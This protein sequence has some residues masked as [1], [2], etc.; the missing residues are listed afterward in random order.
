MKR[1]H[2]LLLLSFLFSLSQL[3]LSAQS[4]YKV[5][6]NEKL[7]HASLIVE[8]KVIS[9]HSFWGPGNQMIFTS[10]QV[11]I[12][13]VF[14]GRVSSRTIEVITQG[15]SV[16]TETL[17]V[18]DLLS[19]QKNDIGT[20]MCF[21]NKWAIR[22]PLTNDVLWDVYSSAQG[23]FK[24]DLASNTAAAPFVRYADVTTQLYTELSQKIGRAY[25]NV[26]AD[27]NISSF[28]QAPN[29]PNAPNITGFS[30]ATV[31]GGATIDVA[32]NLLTI[33]GSGFGTG[34][35]SAA[36]LFD[37]ANDGSGGNM[38]V[39]AYNDPLIVSWADA[40][41]QVRVP[42]RAGTG[43]LQVRDAA[44]VV[45]TAAGTLTVTYAILSGS[46]TDGTNTITKEFNLMNDNGSGG[47]T[48]QYSSNTAGGG[49]DF[50]SAVNKAIF[51]RA[52]STWREV[53]GLRFTEGAS[54][55]SQVVAADGV[56]IVV[57]D[58]SNAGAGVTP[59]PSGVLAVCYSRASMCLP[60]LTNQ[61][62]RTEFDI[63]VRNEP[64]STGT[65]AFSLGPCPPMA[66]NFAEIDLETV[67]LHELGHALNLAHIND[68][69]EGVSAGQLNPGK[70]MN[71][72]VVNSVKRVSPDYS[73]YIGSLYAITPQGNSYGSCGLAS[74]EMT[75]LATTTESRDECPGT[76]PSTNT[77]RNTAITFDLTHATSNKFTDPPYTK[78]NTG[79]TGVGIT[80][81]AFY[82]FKTNNAGGILSLSVTNYTLSPSTP[83]TCAT[84]YG[85]PTIGVELSV[86][87]VN[88]CPAP[89]AYPTP[90]AYRNFNANGAISDITGLAANTTYLIMVDGIENTKASFTLNFT[91]ASLPIGL[92]DFTG[93]VQKKVNQLQWFTDFVADVRQV[94]IERSADGVSFQKIAVASSMQLGK[95]GFTDAL[96]LAGANYYRLATHNQD[97]SMEYSRI[98]LLKRNDPFLLTIYPNP[99]SSVLQAELRTDKSDTY[100]IILR[101][102]SGQIVKQKLTAI[103]NGVQVVPLSVADLH[104]GVYQLSVL[105]SKGAVIK[106][107]AVTIAR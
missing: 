87:Q 35:G 19:L 21:P 22:S 41:I 82:A 8:G 17:E 34:S 63:I 4:L 81:N 71:F 103:R 73:A 78:V 104:P 97:G 52:V 5:E 95:G 33:T 58:N 59:M 76:F 2:R 39:V 88:S 93:S 43:S 16:G 46:L 85:Y 45:Q 54:T 64:V 27:F 15:G 10:N 75:P 96:P 28:K 7:S 83:T 100:T 53:S 36:V 37:D 14:K 6:L 91:G 74:G 105:D 66:N 30:P 86:Y 102:I 92:H 77:P 68:S 56:N 44:G 99:A 84:P 26:K 107:N 50:T 60:I 94:D 40:Q 24:Y 61:V 18:S 9:Q 25:E 32:N 80:N 49:K 67:I 23:F 48:Y 1:C 72:A 55:T 13:K 47:Y 42:S 65:T 51:E 106:T 70:L 89:G 101:N 98:L 12:Y 62:Q 29:Q 3:V 11:E 57:Y 38:F 79:G 20:F 69:Y 31:N 90:I